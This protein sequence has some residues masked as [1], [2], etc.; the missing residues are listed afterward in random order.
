MVTSPSDDEIINLTTFDGFTER[1]IDCSAE[2]IP[3]PDVYWTQNSVDRLGNP[4]VITEDI[5]SD[6]ENVFYCVAE[7]AAGMDQHSV[8]YNVEIPAV[9]TS[10]MEHTV[11]LT[12]LNV[13]DTIECQAD[14]IPTPNVY[15]MVGEEVFVSTSTLMVTGGI[16]VNSSNTFTCVAVNEFGTNMVSVTYVIDISPADVTDTLINIIDEIDNMDT[17]N[18]ETAGQI[19]AVVGNSVDLVL[20][21]ENSTAE[22]NNEV[23]ETAANTLETLV[24]KTNGTLSNET[25]SIVTNTLNTIITS[26]L[27]QTNETEPETVSI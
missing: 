17:I 27:D 2:G 5:L 3:T 16:L 11:T 20:S 23:L 4:L 21:N 18:D 14:G 19:A 6:I 8:T 1:S 13:S 10:P 7:N 15:W 9:I 12:S 24:N 26:T 25:T 22:E